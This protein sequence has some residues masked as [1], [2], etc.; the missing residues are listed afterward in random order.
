MNATAAG[1]PG[2][3]W[4]ALIAAYEQRRCRS[5]TRAS[6]GGGEAATGEH[7]LHL[8]ACD[9][10]LHD[11][12]QEEAENQRPPDLPGHLEAVSERVSDGAQHVSHFDL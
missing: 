3:F 5:E 1:R 12:G 7:A 9:P 10:R 8:P 2:P 6:Q 4:D 11:A